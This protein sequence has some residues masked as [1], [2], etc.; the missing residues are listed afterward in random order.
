MG[1]SGPMIWWDDELCEMLARAGFYVIRYDNR[2]IGRSTRF[3]QAQVNRA[4]LVKAFAGRPVKTP[5][6]MS[7]LAK[8]GF[9]LLDHLRV[10]R[11][12]ILGIS[13]GGMI[14]QTMAIADSER[15]R[16]LTS[17]MST[18]GRRTVGWVDPKLMSALLQPNPTT[19]QAY[20][21]SNLAFWQKIGSPGYPIPPELIRE[22][23]RDTWVRG[24]NPAGVMR[25]M[26]A[27]L[28]QR[29]RTEDLRKLTIP[30]LVIHGDR[31]RMVH[32]SGGRATAL[33]VPGSELLVIKGMGHDLPPALYGTFVK[34]VRGIADRAG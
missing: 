3:K 32:V 10:E 16:S 22:R 5:Y 8:D 24:T 18:V 30:T 26:L 1:L 6:R 9:G 11:A 29:D 7:D 13:M 34:A 4:D 20:I 23:G 2:D 14:A 12:H 17:V 15:V 33:A 21:E 25:Q 27:I 28:T 31:D 19:E